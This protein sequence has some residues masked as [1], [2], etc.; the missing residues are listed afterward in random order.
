MLVV[1]QL[2]HFDSRFES[3]RFPKNSIQLQMAVGCTQSSPFCTVQT[4]WTLY[5][6][7]EELIVFD[8]FIFFKT[9][10]LGTCES[11]NFIRIEPR[12]ESASILYAVNMCSDGANCTNEHYIYVWRS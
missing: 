3:N 6:G 7:T 9:T 1:G 11:E 10:E 5:G 8:K 2:R 12:I 4:V